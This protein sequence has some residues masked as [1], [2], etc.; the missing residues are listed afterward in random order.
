MAIR[1]RRRTVSVIFA[2]A[3]VVGLIA[4]LSLTIHK[5]AP[6]TVS[7]QVQCLS[8]AP[9]SGI[10]IIGSARGFVTP[11]PLAN[12][13]SVANFIYTLPL[14]GS[15]L[16]HIGCGFT[17]SGGWLKSGATGFTSGSGH[18]FVCNDAYPTSGFEP[19]AIKS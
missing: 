7:G 4:A 17:A 13:P 9:V 6:A 2:F 1:I 5:P 12:S 3:A 8:G 16:L 14:G 19:C 10:Y 18:V 15:Y 11:T